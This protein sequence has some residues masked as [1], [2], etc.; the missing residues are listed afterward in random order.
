MDLERL[1]KKKK[2]AKRDGNFQQLAVVVKELGDIY[3]ETGKY[4]DALQEYTEQ[5]E[6]CNMLDDKLNVAV[7][8]RMIGETQANLGAYEE[9]LKHQ[10]HYLEGAKETNS[11]LE[12]QRAYATLGRTYF[13]WGESLVE[14]S[15][16]RPEILSNARKAYMKSIRLCN[17]RDKCRVE[18]IDYYAGTVAFKLGLGTGS[19][20]GTFS[21]CRS[22]GESCRLVRNAQS[23]RRFSQNA[24]RF[25]RSSRT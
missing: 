20:E 6:V 16:N 17:E 24:N 25:G 13:C 21:S 7:A 4:E 8:H 19:S 18:G 9:A 11:L 5:L 12:E 22:H 15:D 14:D 2:R 3:F 10:N 23:A 1:I